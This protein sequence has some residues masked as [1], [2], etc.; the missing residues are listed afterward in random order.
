ME[1][2][3]NFKFIVK[4]V[5]KRFYIV[6]FLT[7]VG[8][9][10]G[11]LYN[12][13]LPITTVYQASAKIYV[14]PNYSNKNDTSHDTLMATNQIAKTYAELIK[15]RAVLEQVTKELSFS[16]NTQ[17]LIDHIVVT[18]SIDNPIITIN[19]TTEIKEQSIEIV[20]KTYQ[21]FLEDQ[22]DLSITNAFVI[23]KGSLHKI[24]TSSR[25]SKYAIMFT[26]ISIIVGIIITFGLEILH[27]DKKK[28]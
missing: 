24:D 28:K 19:Y 3:I 21:A 14:K 20:E 6:V 11:Y 22:I 8:F 27:S 2:Y 1:E 16:I 15:S 4:S 5:W 26:C 18:S 9:L 10:V 23:D 12:Q 13:S 17:D 25:S 7:I